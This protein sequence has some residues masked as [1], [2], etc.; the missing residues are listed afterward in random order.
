MI[1]VTTTVKDHNFVTGSNRAL[2]HK[3]TN[4]SGRF[5]LAV[6]SSNFFI[7]SGGTC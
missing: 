3:G 4:G 1:E 7:K 5:S 6:G 2:R